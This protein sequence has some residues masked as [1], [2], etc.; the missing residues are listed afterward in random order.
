LEQEEKKDDSKKLQRMEGEEVEM[1]GARSVVVTKGR[2][3]CEME[4]LQRKKKGEQKKEEERLKRRK[5]RGFLKFAEGILPETK[6]VPGFQI[7]LLRLHYCRSSTWH[8]RSL[9][10][11]SHSNRYSHSEETILVETLRSEEIDPNYCLILHLS[12]A[13]S[14]KRKWPYFQTKYSGAPNPATRFPVDETV[15]SVYVDSTCRIL[16]FL[17]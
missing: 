14:S 6:R 7:L 4:E 10:R 1:A 3:R 13:C 5:E 2:V 17:R 12:C 16:L 8:S 15:N 11:H 9:I